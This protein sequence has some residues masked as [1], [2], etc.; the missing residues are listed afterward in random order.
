MKN[1]TFIFQ[2]NPY[3]SPKQMV[4]EFKEAINGKKN[5]QP[6]NVMLANDLAVIHRIISKAR[7]KVFASIKAYQPANVHE[8]AQLLHRDYTNVWRD[9]QVLANCGI[10]E[11]K[12]KGKETKPIIL[13]EQIVLDFPV[14]KEVLAKKKEVGSSVQT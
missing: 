11:L 7:L 14:N 12:E 3:F 13:Y 1:K 5:V 8:L 4:G 9:C 2:Y 6:D 10:I